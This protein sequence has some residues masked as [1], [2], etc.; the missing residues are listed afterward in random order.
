LFVDHSATTPGDLILSWSPSCSDGAEDY[1]IYEGQIG[2]WDSHV[3]IDCSDLGADFT[4]QVTPSP[5]DRYYL[6]VPNN[7]DNDGSYGMGSNDVERPAGTP[8]CRS[9]QHLEPCP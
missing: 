7:V 6:V 4:E 5:G 9:S 1:G 8:S 2:D 3:A